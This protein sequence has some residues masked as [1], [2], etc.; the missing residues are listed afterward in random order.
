MLRRL[1]LLRPGILRASQCL[2]LQSAGFPEE[3]L[4]N[5]PYS[6]SI[7]RARIS[8]QQTLHN[9]VLAR[10]ILQWQGSLLLERSQFQCQPRSLIQ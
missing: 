6:V 10:S 5:A 8:L 1:N 7:Q 2:P 9:Q 3:A 4:K